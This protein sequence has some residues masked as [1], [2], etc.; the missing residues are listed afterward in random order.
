[1]SSGGYGKFRHAANLVGAGLL[2]NAECQTTHL[3]LT[4]RV[5]QQAGSYSRSGCSKEMCSA[6]EREERWPIPV[7]LSRVIIPTP[8]RNV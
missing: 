3:Y 7:R 8:T 2:A 6:S 5:R 4:H 1:M